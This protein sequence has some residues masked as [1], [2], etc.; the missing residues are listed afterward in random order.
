MTPTASRTA[1]P[2]ATSTATVIPKKVISIDFNNGTWGSYAD[3]FP[4]QSPPGKIYGI[5]DDPENPGNKYFEAK[6]DLRT[7]VE[8]KDTKIRLYPNLS[9][10]HDGPY[11]V[12]FDVF[13]GED[14]EIPRKQVASFFSIHE[15]TTKWY[16]PLTVDLRL[17]DI[18]YAIFPQHWKRDDTG[19]EGLLSP[20]AKPFLFD[21]WVNV[22]VNVEENG[23]VTVFQNGIFISS[24]VIQLPVMLIRA[25]H[26][27]LYTNQECT[28]MLLQNDNIK[29][30]LF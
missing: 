7:I 9:I 25:S 30:Y 23:I 14:F 6:V 28:K 1:S 26:L 19:F 17:S 20:E 5:V 12:T 13:V 24:N 27:G 3:Y 11:A 8:T 2:S 15:S 29:F 10:V 18:G 16:T 22:L 4:P 21:Q